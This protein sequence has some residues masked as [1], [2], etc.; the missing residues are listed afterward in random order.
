[1]NKIGT[2]LKFK[3]GNEGL[4]LFWLDYKSGALDFPEC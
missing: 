3:I 2:D 4:E 1:M